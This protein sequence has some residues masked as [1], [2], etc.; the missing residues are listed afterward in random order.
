[1][2][3]LSFNL[4]RYGKHGSHRWDQIQAGR[5]REAMSILEF[6]CDSESDAGSVVQR[7]RGGDTTIPSP[8]RS[9][10][11]PFARIAQHDPLPGR[12]ACPNS[13]HFTR[14]LVK[15]CPREG[16]F[17]YRPLQK[18]GNICDIPLPI[19]ARLSFLPKSERRGPHAEEPCSVN[20][21][22]T[23]GIICCPPRPDGMSFHVVKAL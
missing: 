8:G 18:R 12:R 22:P 3:H 11:Q 5:W 15:I 13:T 23:T 17:S 9:P 6:L 7:V 4:P 10:K 20:E 16:L 2:M 19:V 21:D 1:M 14:G